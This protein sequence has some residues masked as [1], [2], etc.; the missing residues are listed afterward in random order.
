[1]AGILA[2]LA[3]A[4]CSSAG[5]APSLS[6]PEMP[7]MPSLDSVAA[8]AKSE[9][10]PQGS[11]TELYARVARGA[12]GCWFAANGP[13]KKDYIY[14]ADADA[15]SRG[16]KAEIMIHMRDTTQP[17]PRGAKA[18]RINIDPKDETSA[19][20]A[21]ENLK[22]PEPMGKAMTD[23]VGRWAR[24]ELGCASAA[25]ASAWAAT[26]PPAAPA[27]DPKAKPAKAKKKT[28]AKRS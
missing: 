13:L 7:K 12:L 16:G 4:G 3:L 26:P 19:T 15:P 22:M 11:A 20:L 1:M 14:H 10:P 21:A 8:I 24:G 25:N 2:A 27:V 23:D 6:L 28:A 9:E 17:N 18:Y 5:E